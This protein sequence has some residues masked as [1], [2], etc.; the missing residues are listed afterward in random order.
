MFA[1]RQERRLFFDESLFGEPAWDMLLLLCCAAAS[2]LNVNANLLTASSGVPAS[3]AV[4]WLAS[5]ESLGLIARRHNAD[6]LFF[7]TV[8]LTGTGR[9][10]MEDYFNTIGPLR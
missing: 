9:A 10:R 2:G 3:V 4:R 5:L 1:D 6:N 8:Q 7:Q